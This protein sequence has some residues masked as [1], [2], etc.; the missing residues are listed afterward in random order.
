MWKL[1]LPSIDMFLDYQRT[2]EE[3]LKA[4]HSTQIS[5]YFD[6]N[7]KMWP[8]RKNCIKF[9]QLHLWFQTDFRQFSFAICDILKGALNLNFLSFNF[10]LKKSRFFQINFDLSFRALWHWK[11][12]IF[13][14]LFPLSSLMTSSWEPHQHHNRLLTSIKLWRQFKPHLRPNLIRNPAANFDF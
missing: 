1:L 13:E 14:I 4:S 7:S 11:L 2:T 5:N 8:Y 12:K 9:Q 6:E 10:E 3:K